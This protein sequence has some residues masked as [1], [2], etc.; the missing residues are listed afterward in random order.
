MER[1]EF[2]IQSVTLFLELFEPA[3]VLLR[4]LLLIVFEPFESVDLQLYIVPDLLDPVLELGH[5]RSSTLFLFRF[6][7]LEKLVK[8]GLGFLDLRKA[9]FQLIQVLSVSP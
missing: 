2:V 6:K 8:S 9:R 1:K 3:L 5:H 4:Y 7:F